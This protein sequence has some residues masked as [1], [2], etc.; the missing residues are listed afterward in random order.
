MFFKFNCVVFMLLYV[1][2]WNLANND[3]RLECCEVH[4]FTKQSALLG[5][6]VR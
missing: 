5:T 4:I 6:E 3:F 1:H 2:Y